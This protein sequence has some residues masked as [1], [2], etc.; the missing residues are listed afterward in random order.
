MRR[1]LVEQ[2]RRKCSLKHGGHWQKQD[3]E[4]DQ[5]CQPGAPEE[6]LAVDEALAKLARENPMIARLVELRYFAGLSPEE[7]A[8]ALG[9]SGRTGRRYW[10][11]AKAWLIEELRGPDQH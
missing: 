3:V 9:V 10:L 7:S 8:S 2:A 5:A 11:Y 6:V 1:I 4:L